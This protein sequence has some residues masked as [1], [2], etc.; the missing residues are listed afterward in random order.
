MHILQIIFQIVIAALL[1]RYGSKWARNNWEILD[2]GVGFIPLC[3]CVA[4]VL[5]GLGIVAH[6]L[7]LV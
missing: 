3:F 7:Q 1:I 6:V 2:Q 5:G 4:M